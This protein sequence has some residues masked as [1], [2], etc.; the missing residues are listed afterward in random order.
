MAAAS[1][2]S[3]TRS[4]RSRAWTFDLPQALANAALHVQRL[5]A[6]SGKTG[7]EPNM[8]SD[9]ISSALEPT[10]PTKTELH[11]ESLP[12]RLQRLPD[13]D[14][15]TERIQRPFTTQQPQPQPPHGLAL[16]NRR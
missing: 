10:F 8:D 16:R 9:G 6:N 14:R 7:C 12:C 11:G 3:A 1:T 4:S 5:E 15:N 13:R 2:V